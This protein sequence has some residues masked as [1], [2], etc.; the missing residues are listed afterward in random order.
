MKTKLIGPCTFDDANTYCTNSDGKYRLPTI[1]E[2]E[3]ITLSYGIENTAFWSSTEDSEG[4]VW[5]GSI[6]NGNLWKGD[7]DHETSSKDGANH[8]ALI[9]ELKS[10][11]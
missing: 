3:E 6:V 11:K 7:D 2:L 9:I 5:T 8:Y 10:I 1:N 4:L